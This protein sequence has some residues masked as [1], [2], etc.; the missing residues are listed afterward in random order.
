MTDWKE[1][2]E[3]NYFLVGSPLAFSGP[4]KVY[5]VL[6]A[7]NYKVSLKDVK[8]WL[9][10][11]DSYTLLRPVKKIFHRRSIITTGIDHMWDADLADVSNTSQS[12]D[13]TKFL[14][15]V[16]DI[17]S[18]FLWVQPLKSKSSKDVVDG[19][20]AI[21]M[22]TPRRPK[23][24]RTDNGKEFRNRTLASLFKEKSIKHFTTKN[25]TKANYAERVI[26]TLKGLMY[27][28]FIQNQ[29]YTYLNILQNL[30]KTYNTRPHRSLRG[31][32][33]N[34][35]STENEFEVWRD[36][37]A[38]KR[39]TVLLKLMKKFKFNVGDQ[40]R[41]SHLGYKFQR[42]YQEKWTEEVFKISFRVKRNGVKLY[43]L[44]DF[45]GEA[46]EGT[47]YESELQKVTQ[48]VDTLFRI[49]SIIG[50]RKRQGRTQVLIKWMGWPKKFNSWIDETEIRRI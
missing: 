13:D 20:T 35:I 24:I 23:K 8:K 45:D 12:N 43:K 5:K 32:S 21:F 40:V 46:I 41:I 18:R 34:E 44:I 33:P 1:Y 47:F 27:R 19:F 11:K 14:L 48:S 22:S 28:Y 37:Y 36:L 31:R 15:I 9:Q 10:D 2:L 49:E 16:I 6:K 29:T 3:N 26:R 38:R 4:A 17:F 25:E 30:V 7:L 42:D 50:R 39:K